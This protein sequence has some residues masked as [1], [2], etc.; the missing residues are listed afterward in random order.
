MDVGP[1]IVQAAVSVRRRHAPTRWPR[2]CSS[3]STVTST[4]LA[5]AAMAR[6]RPGR[7]GGPGAGRDPLALACGRGAIRRAE[8]ATSVTNRRRR[9]LPHHRGGTGPARDSAR[10][11]HVGRDALPRPP[12]RSTD[13]HVAARAFA[14]IHEAQ[15][16]PI[17]HGN[18]ATEFILIFRLYPRPP[19]LTKRDGGEV[20]EAGNLRRHDMKL[21]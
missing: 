9:V 12:Q 10:S 8:P 15:T 13:R 5:R 4:A 17:G 1:I 6:R 20:V 19:S 3:R 2:G 18:C 7:R 21:S 16:L 14:T 11:R